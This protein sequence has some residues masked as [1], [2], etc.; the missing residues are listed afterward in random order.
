VGFH[1]TIQITWLKGG[2][3]IQIK[4]LGRSKRLDHPKSKLLI[5]SNHII[6]PFMRENQNW[7]ILLKSSC[8]PLYPIR[9]IRNLETHVGQL[10]KQLADNQ[11][12]QFSANLQTNPKEHCKF[13]TTRC[14]EV[15][16]KGIGDNLVVEEEVLKEKKIEKEHIECERGER[17]SK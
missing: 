8:K 13:I 4:V 3:I 14:G 6:L 12:I 17:R 7:R 10:A 11:G 9:K 5:S 1:L 15:I 16:G 2:G